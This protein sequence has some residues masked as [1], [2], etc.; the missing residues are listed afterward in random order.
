MLDCIYYINSQEVVLIYT[1]RSS[2]ILWSEEG[3]V[4]ELLDEFLAPL[5]NECKTIS[6]YNHRVKVGE[7]DTL[8]INLNEVA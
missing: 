3:R 7:E 1:Y 5:D 8:I 2:V 4:L 6:E